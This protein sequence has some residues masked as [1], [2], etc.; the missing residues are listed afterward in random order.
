VNQ[1]YVNR[2]LVYTD[3][4]EVEKRILVPTFSWRGVSTKSDIGIDEIGDR[5]VR[6]RDEVS[7]NTI[8]IIDNVIDNPIDNIEDNLIDNKVIELI[9]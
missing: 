2:T 5:D 4:K 1:G 8:K 6:I 3:R 9:I 7:T